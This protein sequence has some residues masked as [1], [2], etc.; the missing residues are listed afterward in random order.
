MRLLRILDPRILY[1]FAAVFVIPVCLVLNPSRRTAYQY[2][3]SRHHY[4]PLRAAWATYVNHC[5]FAQA[6]IDKFAMYAGNTITT[7]WHGLEHY[8]RLAAQQPGFLFLSSHIGNYEIAGSAITPETKTFNALVFAGEK[9]SVIDGRNKILRQHNMCMIPVRD[10]MSHLFLIDKALSE[11][12]IVS[13]PADRINGSPKTV[14]VTLLDRQ[15]QLPQGPFSVATMRGLNVLAC[16]V[17]KERWNKYA[18]HITP[19]DYDR[20]APRRKQIQQLADAYAADLEQQLRRY[21]TQWY[22]FYDFWEPLPTSPRGR[23]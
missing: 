20:S 18:I 8:L 22:N 5:L 17:M 6:V 19:L 14:T 3:R 12:D 7:E 16:S 23:S 4:N 13:M 9:Q 21:P 2:F 10:D 1:A 11:G 15:A